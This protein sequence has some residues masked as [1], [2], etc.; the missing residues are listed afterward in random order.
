MS[1][2]PLFKGL[3]LSFAVVLY[4]L[5]PLHLPPLSMISCRHFHPYPFRRP[6][7]APPM[8]AF[9][10]HCREVTRTQSLGTYRDT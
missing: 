6:E 4:N 1:T 5:A 3:P 10:C 7:R 9:H 2:Y 8:R